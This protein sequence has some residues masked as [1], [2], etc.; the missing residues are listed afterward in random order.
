MIERTVTA[1]EQGKR[2]HRYVRALYPNEPLGVLYALIDK[3]AVRVNGKRKHQ[4]YV[5]QA[6]D[7]VRIPL[8]NPTVRPMRKYVGIDRSI[9]IVYEDDALLVVAKPAGL[10]IHP[11]HT[12][13]RGGTLIDRVHAVL[14]DRGQLDSAVFLPATAHRLDR[15]TSGLVLIGKTAQQ[16][17]T[18]NTWFQEGAIEKTYITIV[19][20]VL[21]GTGDIRVAL[22]RDEASQ[23]TVPDEHGRSAWTTFVVLDTTP[24]YSLVQIALHSGRTHQI[25]AHVH[26]IGH[27]IVGD[28]KYGGAPVLPRYVLHAWR[29]RLPDG[30]TFCAPMPPYV[31]DAA[32]QL[33]VRFPRELACAHDA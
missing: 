6:Q 2:L 14:Y 5:L 20:G 13:P 24:H 32:R 21:R 9:D 30:R 28:T 12:M 22:R 19:H 11:D 4:N 3:G 15:N 7:V 8:D 29:V 25:R 26:A 27:P 31:H 17:H 23:T 33:R 1:S 18:L 10:L 16:L